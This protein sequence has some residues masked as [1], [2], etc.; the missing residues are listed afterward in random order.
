MPK[1][2][3]ATLLLPVAALSLRAE[4]AAAP[5]APSAPAQGH[6]HEDGTALDDKMEAMNGAFRKLRRQI[7]DASAN[8]SS[9]EL[10]AKLRKGAEE[11]AKLTP[12]KA[13]KIPEADRAKFVADYEAK[14]KEF[15]AEVDNLKAALEAG[16]NEEA[17]AIV[18]KLGS[19]QKSGH[20]EFRVPKKD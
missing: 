10:V 8:A 19:L 2:I 16:K 11:S 17:A 15:I 3:L 12:E 5:T 18:A 14:M 4:P 1:L 6:K 20:R 13:E 9:L 7:N